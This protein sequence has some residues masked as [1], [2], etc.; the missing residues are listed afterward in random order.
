MK[1]SLRVLLPF[2]ALLLVLS[3]ALTGCVQQEEPPADKRIIVYC[4]SGQTSG[5]TVAILRLLGYDAV[6]LHSGMGVGRTGDRG[7][8]NEGFETT[9]N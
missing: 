4:Y 1:K 3:L 9:S 8:A 6:S 7:W 5:Q 2:L